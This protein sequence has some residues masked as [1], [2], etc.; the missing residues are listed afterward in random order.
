MAADPAR[1][2]LLATP[3]PP[4]GAGEHGRA[5]NIWYEVQVMQRGKRW[6]IHTIFDDRSLALEEARRV[7][8]AGRYPYIRVIE[9][10]FDERTGDNKSMTL[11][12]GGTLDAA[13]QKPE[14]A[15]QKPEPTRQKQA[16]DAM[17]VRDRATRNDGARAKRPAAARTSIGPVFW[18]L[19]GIALGAAGA[20]F[21]VH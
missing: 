9:E 3:A 7:N 2:D 15:Q 17:Q 5:R 13:Q 1:R 6:G 10:S 11:Y 4:R 12:R 21:I 18:L 14:P 16:S 8:D 19:L 20:V